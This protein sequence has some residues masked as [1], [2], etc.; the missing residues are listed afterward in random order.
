MT[1]KQAILIGSVISA[2][3]IGYISEK[4]NK[5]FKEET[6]RLVSESVG[7]IFDK[8]MEEEEARHMKAM[9]DILKQYECDAEEN[10]KQFE[11]EMKKLGNLKLDIESHRKRTEQL[12]SELG[13]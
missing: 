3:I 1:N 11:V 4:Q 12:L 2:V 7:Q 6:D 9:D 8:A 10:R 13:L 5:K